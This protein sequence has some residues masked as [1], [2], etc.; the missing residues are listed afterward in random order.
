MN[1]DPYVEARVRVVNFFNN[2]K[3]DEV[4]P[5]DIEG[6]RVLSFS[7][8]FDNW[9]AW[10]ATFH[11]DDHIYEVSFQNDVKETRLNVY[12]KS[13][14]FTIVDTNDDDDQLSLEFE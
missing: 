5:L 6:T 2:F 7:S 8:S 11:K 9:T 10:V 1:L 13:Y 4:E 3:L 12:T 14:T